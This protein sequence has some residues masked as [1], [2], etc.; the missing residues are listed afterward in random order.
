MSDW[1]VCRDWE[2][3]SRDLSR[4]D[5]RMMDA[6]KWV[7][8]SG[9]DGVSTEAVFAA[10]V[11]KLGAGTAGVLARTTRLCAL[12]PEASKRARARPRSR[13]ETRWTLKRS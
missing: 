1:N 8:R 10:A 9:T 6:R 7:S 11:R 13:A 4:W 12:M 5:D 3:L 2:R